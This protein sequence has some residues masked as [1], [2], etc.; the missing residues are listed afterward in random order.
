MWRMDFFGSL[1]ALVGAELGDLRLEWADMRQ[2]RLW[3]N[4]R[5]GEG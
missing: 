2:I 4:R 5:T 1:G 3:K